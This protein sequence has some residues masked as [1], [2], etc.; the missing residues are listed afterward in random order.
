MHYTLN[1]FQSHMRLHW[2]WK[3]DS[4]IRSQ[5][6]NKREWTLYGVSLCLLMP[7]TWFTLVAS[8]NTVNII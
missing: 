3:L 2:D 4:T 1:N 7:S 8:M 6:V 5:V